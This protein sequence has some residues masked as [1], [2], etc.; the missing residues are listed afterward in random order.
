MIAALS[1]W[2]NYYVIVGSSAGALTGLQFVV[3][4][5]IAEVTRSSM[6]QVA[7]FGTPT[8]VHFCAAL[9]IAAIISAPWSSLAGISSCLVIVGLAGIV[10]G[11][12]VVRRARS[13][14]GYRPVLSDWI[15][16]TVLPMTGYA[17]ILVAALRLVG[18]TSGS[19]FVIGGATLL[20]L[21]IG[22]HNSWDTVTYVAL[23]NRPV[24]PSDREPEHPRRE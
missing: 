8:V 11:I 22:I 4:T 7:A 24:R 2:E 15:W 13:Q 21:F 18:H 5:L 17:A 3:I 20:F 10:Y 14:E 23:T 9:L 6:Q 12:V 1:D 19:L 16:H